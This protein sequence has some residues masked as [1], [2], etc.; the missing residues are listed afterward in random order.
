MV[1]NTAGL[2]LPACLQPDNEIKAVGKADNLYPV[3]LAI[4]NHEDIGVQLRIEQITCITKGRAND[5][6]DER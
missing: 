4:N 1:E 2:A 6:M 5:N 3:K